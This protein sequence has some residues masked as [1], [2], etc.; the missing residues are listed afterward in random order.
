MFRNIYNAKLTIFTDT[1]HVFTYWNNIYAAAFSARES[2]SDSFEIKFS[3]L[4]INFVVLIFARTTG[5]SVACRE[6]GSV[7]VRVSRE[8]ECAQTRRE[9]NNILIFFSVVLMQSCFF[10]RFFFRY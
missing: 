6:C 5:A 7:L 3:V 9:R 10:W 8:R 2:W 1:Q 4:F